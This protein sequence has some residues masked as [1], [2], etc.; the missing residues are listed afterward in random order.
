MSRPAADRASVDPRVDRTTRTAARRRHSGECADR[1]TTPSQRGK[2]GAIVARL[3]EVDYLRM[4]YYDGAAGAGCYPLDERLQIR[5]EVSVGLEV[6]L[7]RQLVRLC[8]LL[9]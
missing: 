4:Y 1:Q 2:K 3:G 6:G 7:E 8:A 5:G 9:A